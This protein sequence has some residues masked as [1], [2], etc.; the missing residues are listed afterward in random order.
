M[1]RTATFDEISSLNR[2]IAQ[3]AREL[4]QDIY[5]PE[6]IE[7]A[8]SYVFGV[9]SEL[10]DD[11]SYYVIE[12]NGTIVACGG[13]SRR[14]TLFG[15]NQFHER[16]AGFLN[17]EVDAAKIRT[18]FVHPQHSRKGLGKMLLDY[19]EQQAVAH[20]FS[21]MEMMATLP[22]MK[23]YQACGYLSLSKEQHLLPNG[24]LLRF[25]RMGKILK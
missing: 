13:W 25:V 24:V 8:I 18:F 4:S 10:L 3:S 6:E 16:K 11:Q 9:D 2:L 20:G 7:G 23:L 21:S 15:G 19:C 12:E 14:K 5:S 17:P 22:G 1:I